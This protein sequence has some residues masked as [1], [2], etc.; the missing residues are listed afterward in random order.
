MIAVKILSP[1]DNIF[2]MLQTRGPCVSYRKIFV[3]YQKGASGSLDTARAGTVMA[4]HMWLWESLFTSVNRARSLTKSV[5][6][7]VILSFPSYYFLFSYL[8][9]RR[10]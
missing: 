3:K 4:L 7:L 10:F 1:A 5:L 8:S 2:F 9:K 6:L